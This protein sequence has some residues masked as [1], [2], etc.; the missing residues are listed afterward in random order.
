MGR[1]GEG[2]RE[3]GA[4]GASRERI[5]YFPTLWVWVHP[6]PGRGRPGAG[7][8]LGRAAC[9]GFSCSASDPRVGAAGLSEHGEQAL[10]SSCRHCQCHPPQGHRH[11]RFPSESKLHEPLGPEIHGSL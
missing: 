9:P 5:G 6:A 3:L 11:Q 10:A 8:R 7:M 1:G 2:E 4:S